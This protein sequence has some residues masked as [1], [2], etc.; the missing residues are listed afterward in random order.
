MLKYNATAWSEL[1]AFGARPDTFSLGVCN[2]CQLMALLGW[3]PGAAA[4]GDGA[5]LRTL[6]P[7]EQ[8][9]F[10]HNESGRFE[11][12]F[13]SVTVK[14]SPAVLLE[15]MEGSSLGVW[16][17]HGEGRAHF[18]DASVYKGVLDAELA[19]LR[20]VDDSNRPTSAYPFNPNGSADGIA[21]LCSRD[22]RH[23]AMMPHPER[24][25]QSWQWPWRPAEWEGFESGPWLKLFHNARSFC[26]RTT[27]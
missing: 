20:Y 5:E 21:A 9:R 16:V 11:S 13:S 17:A 3:V 7:L 14:R 2:G 25:F 6:P 12:R 19:P 15:G 1:Q 18:P 23:L 4:A 26:D 8:P 24:C 10:V 22:G 27:A